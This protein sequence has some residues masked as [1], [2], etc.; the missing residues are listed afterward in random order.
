MCI[1]NWYK[2][3]KGPLV[4]AHVLPLPL[5]SGDS[6]CP[7]PATPL[8]SASAS[9]LSPAGASLS[10]PA[11]TSPPAPDCACPPS[12]AGYRTL[13]ITVLTD[14]VLVHAAAAGACVIV[15]LPRMR[16]V[17]V[18]LALG[19]LERLTLCI[20]LG[21]QRFQ[22]L[23]SRPPGALAGWPAGGDKVVCRRLILLAY[24]LLQSTTTIGLVS[25][26]LLHSCQASIT[27]Q[28]GHVLCCSSG[29]WFGWLGP[30]VCCQS[31][32]LRPAPAF[33]S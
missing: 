20:T 11:C 14:G 25:R 23:R 12:T 33:L 21:P 3:V 5:R 9:T 18:L 7:A 17:L 1:V 31:L 30:G 27:M 8:S 15:L 29:W 19:L 6:S 10:S 13:F 32:T 28:S 16:R 24:T 22:H 26:A 2:H 4:T